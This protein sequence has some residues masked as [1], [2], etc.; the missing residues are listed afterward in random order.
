MIICNRDHQHLTEIK[1][2]DYNLENKSLF[3]GL[4]LVIGI[5]LAFLGRHCDIRTLG[6]VQLNGHL[7]SVETMLLTTNRGR[8]LSER[9][10]NSSESSGTCLMQCIKR[11]QRIATPHHRRFYKTP[12]FAAGLGF[13]AG[14]EFAAG[15][16]FAV[17]YNF[18]E[19]WGYAV[20]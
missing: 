14:W 12:K 9:T 11:S 3:L 16:G 1:T 17:G 5:K 19:D 10:R 15:L 6:S 8:Y 4:E 20:N 7:I 2:G 13:V 18:A